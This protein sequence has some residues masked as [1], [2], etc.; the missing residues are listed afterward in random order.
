MSKEIKLCREDL[1][2]QGSTTTQL[3]PH[4]V[5][6]RKL[7]CPYSI[8][9]VQAWL[10]H[11][12]VFLLW[13]PFAETQMNTKEQSRT[14]QQVATALLEKAH[15]MQLECGREISSRMQQWEV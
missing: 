8:S 1:E 14:P 7:R 13:L 9:P 12:V 10:E 6:R 3:V 15:Q 2:M 5:L 4:L 11:K